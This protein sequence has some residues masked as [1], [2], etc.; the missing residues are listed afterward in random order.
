MPEFGRRVGVVA[1]GGCSVSRG[2]V[3]RFSLF[4]TL[5]VI[6]LNSIPLVAGVN[7]ANDLVCADSGSKLDQFV[8]HGAVDGIAGVN[9]AGD[10]SALQLFSFC[11]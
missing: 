2:A 4:V 10:C 6:V 5:G 8:T 11:C 1:L 9:G 7:I 3:R